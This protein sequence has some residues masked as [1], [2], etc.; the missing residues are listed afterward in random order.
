MAIFAVGDIHGCYY[1]LTT[2]LNEIPYNEN[3]V[4]IF[5]GDYVDRGSRT[6]ESIDFLIEF[7]RKNDSMFL[8]G[9]HEIMMLT[10]RLGSDRLEDWEFCG[11]SET[12]RSY[13]L[14]PG[15]GW[16]EKIPKE[17][18]DFLEAT[19]P[20]HQIDKYIFVHAGLESG[21][22]LINQNRHSLYWEK[23][24]TP[25][26]YSDNN[27]VICGHTSRK[28]GNIADFDHTIC[29][30]T[31]VY[32]GKWLTALNVETGEYYQASERKKVRKG[33]I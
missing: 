25:E 15:K 20:F 13:K 17:H 28:D 33:V 7:S 9:N 11:G 12:L 4:F 21:V 10:A 5:L 1:A 29:I 19:E 16:H 27:I 30:D 23:Y 26:K 3:D 14:K 31:F 32:G 6:K 2:L 22:P 8:R 18:W 24:I